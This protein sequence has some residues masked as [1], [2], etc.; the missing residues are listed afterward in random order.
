MKSVLL[1]VA[2]TLLP[3][4]LRADIDAARLARIDT[5]AAEQ[6]QK[7]NIPGAVVVVVHNDAV[8]YR[9]AFGHRQQPDKPMTFDAVFDMASLTKSIA[10][11]TSVMRLVEDGKIRVADPVAKYWPAFAAN[12]KESVTVEHC[13]LHTAGLIADNSI[14]DY[15]GT[16]DDMLGRIAELK[17]E[18]PPG[19]RFKYSDVGYI[20]LGELV[21]KISGQPLDVFAAENVFKPLMLSH[22]SYKPAAGL[23]F[24]VSGIRDGKV[25]AGEVHDPRAFALGGVAGH[26]GLFS[27]ADDVTRYC[28]MLMRG[29]ELDGTRLLSPLTVKYFTDPHAVPGG[30]RSYGWDVDTSYSGERGDL[31]PPGDGFGHTGFTGTSVWID[32]PTKTA[33]IILTNRLHPDEKK[34]NAAEIRR[35]VANIVASAITTDSGRLFAQK[36]TAARTGSVLTG[37]DVLRRDKFASLKGKNVGLVTNHTGRAAD[38]TPTIDLF[39]KADGVKLVAL[40]SPEHGIRGE[41]DEK[42]GDGKDEQTGLPVFSLYGERR[43][44]T[45]DTLKGID[46]LVYDIQ[47]I[48]CRFYTYSSTLGLVLEAAKENGLRVVV[49]DRPNP[50]GGVLVEGPVRDAG[51]GSFVGYHDVPLRHGLT[52]G[53]MA[54]LF[55]IE[56]KVGADLEIVTCENWRRGDTFERTGLPWRNPSPN[57]RHLTAAMLYPGVGLLETTNVSVGRGTERPFEWIGAPWIDGRKLAAELNRA[58]LPGVKFVPTSRTPTGSTFKDKECGGIDILVEDWN[59]LRPVPVGLTMAAALRKLY[60]REW[61]TKRFDTLLLH[62]AT[63]DGLTAGQSVAELEKA[64]QPEL[65]KYLARRAAVLLYEE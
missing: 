17:L 51:R 62:K 4:L 26:A 63:F 12:G 33:I 59:R 61:E 48:G 38:G 20:V 42:V 24:A 35:Q 60:P 3:S 10:T 25:I 23:P 21:A 34:G 11:G 55:N 49:L 53:E 43:K 44:P 37:I 54:K 19:T 52:V 7:A 56:R 18:A 39:A 58:K 41:K 50:I 2:F 64:W 46:T 13:L 27:T 32:P 1:A 65:Q 30:Q 40:F 16:R 57:M 31:F 45:A 6:I 29:G 36:T 15:V 9:K 5:I 28:R 47:D 22:T 8:V 14:K